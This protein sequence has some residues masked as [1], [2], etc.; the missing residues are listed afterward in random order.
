[1]VVGSGELKK[2]LISFLKNVRKWKK[3]TIWDLTTFKKAE[4]VIPFTPS[5]EGAYA[6]LLSLGQVCGSLVTGYTFSE[7]LILSLLTQNMTAKIYL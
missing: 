5:I 3:N 6:A 4:G 7:A 2:D 1:M